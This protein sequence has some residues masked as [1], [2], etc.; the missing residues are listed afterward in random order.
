MKKF[1]ITV[2]SA[3]AL[4][5]PAFAQTVSVGFTD[6]KV[7]NS[8]HVNVEYAVDLENDVE[9]VVEARLRTSGQHT[10][11][12]GVQR[13]FAQLGP[14]AVSG[15]L[16]LFHDF[17]KTEA[18]GLSVEPT[19]SFKLDG[20]TV[21]VGYEMGDTIQQRDNYKVRNTTVSVMYPFAL[22]NFGVQFEKDTGAAKETAVSFVYSLKN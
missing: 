15:R 3:L 4:T 14:V 2:A 9:G 5:A 1:L 13:E 11:K 16:N 22:G 12:V 10:A 18:T 19:A 8:A 21:K 20:A 6:G 7:K 17:G